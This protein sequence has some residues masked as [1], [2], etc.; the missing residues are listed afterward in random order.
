MKICR[1]LYKTKKHQGIVHG[2][3]KPRKSKLKLICLD[4]KSLEE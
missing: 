4:E 1:P 3:E 2:T